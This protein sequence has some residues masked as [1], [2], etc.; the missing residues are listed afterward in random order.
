MSPEELLGPP[1]PSSGQVKIAVIPPG[2]G[3]GYDGLAAGVLRHQARVMVQCSGMDTWHT[4][5]R[6]YESLIRLRERCLRVVV[7]DG[8]HHLPTLGLIPDIIIVP[9]TAGYAAHSYMPDAMEVKQLL[10]LLEE[11]D[12]PAA[13][14]T[15]PAGPLETRLLWEL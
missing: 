4:T 7:F 9:S 14:V 1:E 12:C 6:G 5:A 8:G 11:T 2:T 10:Q 13:L 15:V 3:G